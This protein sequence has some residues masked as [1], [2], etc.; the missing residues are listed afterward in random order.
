MSIITSGSDSRPP[1]AFFPPDNMIDGRNNGN[2]LRCV[3]V[4]MYIYI[5]IHDVFKISIYIC[6]NMLLF[7]FRKKMDRTWPYHLVSQIC[8]QQFQLDSGQRMSPLP[9]PFFVR[10][11]DSKTPCPKA[12][13][14]SWIAIKWSN[15]QR[16]PWMFRVVLG[17]WNPTQLFLGN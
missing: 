16:A 4:C 11:T 10:E 7:N 8:F 2:K 14:G 13:V 3:F 15:E 17:G 6:K 9:T 12:A 1:K 5:C